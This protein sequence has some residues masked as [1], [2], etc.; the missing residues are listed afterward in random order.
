[1]RIQQILENIELDEVTYDDID[2]FN[3]DYG[4]MWYNED[5]ILD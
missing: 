4:V 3:E 1:M 5:D 2:K